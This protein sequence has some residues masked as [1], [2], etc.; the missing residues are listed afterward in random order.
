MPEMTGVEFAKTTQTTLPAL[1][2]I[3]VTG[4]GNREVLK[5][6]GEAR[7]LQKSYTDTELLEKITEALN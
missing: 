7:I 6:F 5:D 3:L 4:Y 1:P 2:V